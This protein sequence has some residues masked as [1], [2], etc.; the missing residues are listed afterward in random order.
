MNE[1]IMIGLTGLLTLALALVAVKLSKLG[2]RRSALAIKVITVLVI[3]VGLIF[4]TSVIRTQAEAARF[5]ERKTQQYSDF[6]EVHSEKLELT[7]EFGEKIE[8]NHDNELFELVSM[9]DYDFKDVGV[10]EL[11]FTIVDEEG[12]ELELVAQVTIEDTQFPELKNVKDYSLTEGGEYTHGKLE[13]TAT[14]PVDGDLMLTFSG[15]VDSTKPGAYKV[16]VSATDSNDNTTEQELTVTVNKKPE[17]KPQVTAQTTGNTKQTGGSVAKGNSGN[18]GNTGGSAQGSS[19]AAPGA[20]PSQPKEPNSQ[21][22]QSIQFKNKL[23]PYFNAGIAGGQKSMDSKPQ[24]ATT[25]E[26][27]GSK[28]HNNNDGIPTYFGGHNYG[29]FR[30]V[31]DMQVGE[32]FVIKDHTGNSTTY[33]ATARY[34]INVSNNNGS[35]HGTTETYEKIYA[36]KGEG[37]MLQTCVFGDNSRMILIEARPI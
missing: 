23:V 37:V 32:T 34:Y 19:P 12:W 15:D 27:I 3:M 26:V 25:W 36:F 20:A 28:T 5:Q 21:P 24:T 13:I 7:Y 14:D 4:T 2:K 31:V 16:T 22:N 8:I 10:Y 1:M 6:N 11:P 9:G 33:K 29:A 35:I 17:P 18:T 30:P